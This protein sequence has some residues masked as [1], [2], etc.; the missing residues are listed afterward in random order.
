MTASRGRAPVSRRERPAKP[1]LS[2]DGIVAVA[3]RI[4]HEE[5]LEKATM[6]RLAQEL[7]TG[8][9][10]LYVYVRNTAEL[11]GAVLDQLLTTID[12]SPEA[13]AGQWRERLIELLGAYTELLF[14]RPS[15]ARSALTLRPTGPHYLR[16]VDSL[17]ALLRAG[18]VPVRQAAWGVDLLVQ[19]ATATAAEQGTRKETGAG[20][21]LTFYVQDVP[22]AEYPDIAR[23]GDEL[24]SGT[25]RQRGR[26]AFEALIDGIATTGTPAG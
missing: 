3:V 10:S 8:A 16:L 26:W 17:L 14:T 18:D 11:H 15:L 24:I 23:V 5:G 25:G 2:R 20:D 22:A 7:D 1:A 9:A 6:R 4:M 13:P 21:D 12:L 19:L